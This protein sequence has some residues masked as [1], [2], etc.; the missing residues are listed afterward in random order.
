MKSFKQIIKQISESPANGYWDKVAQEREE[1]ERENSIKNG[2][3]TYGGFV[4]ANLKDGLLEEDGEV[5]KASKDH[6]LIY[7]N[8][9]VE[10]HLLDNRDKNN[11]GKTFHVEYLY[12]NDYIR[13][14]PEWEMEE[15]SRFDIYKKV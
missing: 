3:N 10:I 9:P 6:I 4:Y 7:E 13:I 15:D 2:L 8:S 14:N 12:I 11:K 5:I 1:E